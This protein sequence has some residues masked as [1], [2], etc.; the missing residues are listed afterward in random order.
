MRSSLNTTYNELHC[1]DFSFS[2]N[3]VYYDRYNNNQAYDGLLDDL[4]YT[5]NYIAK[6]IN[7]PII[8]KMQISL[9]SRSY[10]SQVFTKAFGKPRY[11]EER[12]SWVYKV[13]NISKGY[14]NEFRLSKH[15]KHFYY[16]IEFEGNKEMLVAVSPLLKKFPKRDKNKPA[17]LLHRIEIASDTPLIRISYGKSEKMLCCLA[18]IAIPLNFKASM[19]IISGKKYKKT[20]DNAINGKNTFYFHALVKQNNGKKKLS[21]KCSW[22]GKMYLKKINGIWHIRCEVTLRYG[23]LKRMIGNYLP[24]DLT[25]LE[26]RIHELSI[27]DFWTFEI[28]DVYGFCSATSKA[29]KNKKTKRERRRFSLVPKMLKEGAKPYVY[30]QKRTALKLVRSFKLS[31]IEKKYNKEDSLFPLNH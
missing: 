26:Q 7:K 15:N 18:A 4:E 20:S 5:A 14:S 12:D 17:A 19:K 8:D 30:L 25:L 11:D 3:N 21:A 27:T 28:F 31:Y 29:L 6:N 22:H 9:Y 16:L 13:K 10:P 23:T 1:D 24:V 2:Y